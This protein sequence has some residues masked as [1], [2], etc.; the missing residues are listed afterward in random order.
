MMMPTKE[1]RKKIAAERHTVALELRKLYDRYPKAF[2]FYV[3]LLQLENWREVILPPV[4][5]VRGKPVIPDWIFA[6]LLTQY[7]TRPSGESREAFI[8]RMAD[9]GLWLGGTY[10]RTEWDDTHT[11]TAQLKAAE[12]RAK[13]DAD[14]AANVGRCLDWVTSH[15]PDVAVHWWQFEFIYPYAQQGETVHGPI[16]DPDEGLYARYAEGFGCDPETFEDQ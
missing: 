3:S 6:S 7:R 12:K 13:V 11:V 9:S 16:L 5:L 4:D 1:A 15:P 2:E 8:A 10:I 14:F